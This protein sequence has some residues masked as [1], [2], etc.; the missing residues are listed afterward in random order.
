MKKL[1]KAKVRTGAWQSAATALYLKGLPIAEIGRRVKKNR[2]T[3]SKFLHS[4]E[5]ELK[6]CEMVGVESIREVKE[7]IKKLTLR[8]LDIIKDILYSTDEETKIVRLK[9][10]QDILDRCGIKE[11][12]SVTVTHNVIYDSMTQAIKD[13]AKEVA[14][15]ARTGHA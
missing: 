4:K 6:V 5:T 11:S 15:E 14:K 1:S 12:D 3:V 9:L 10:A 8:S 7:E 13:T 2:T